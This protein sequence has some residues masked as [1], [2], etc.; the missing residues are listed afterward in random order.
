MRVSGCLMLSL[1]LNV[2]SEEEQATKPWWLAWA[3]H[4][5]EDQTSSHILERTWEMMTKMF[6]SGFPYPWAMSRV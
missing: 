1:L 5:F 2:E 4:S 6:S 3:H